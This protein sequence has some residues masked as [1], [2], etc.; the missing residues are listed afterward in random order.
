MSAGVS[1][2]RVKKSVIA[3]LIVRGRW[4]NYT[5]SRNSSNHRG[6]IPQTQ[7]WKDFLVF[8]CRTLGLEGSLPTAAAVPAPAPAQT[9]AAVA[10][11][12]PAVPS[13]SKRR[14]IEKRAAQ[15]DFATLFQ[16]TVS[17]VLLDVVYDA[18]IIKTVVAL[19]ARKYSLS[20]TV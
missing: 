10:A 9:V 13:A 14:R 5:T 19:Q 7:A 11:Q 18:R 16:F 6:A 20:L 2:E 17:S 3:W 15:A 1:D 4:L 8:V 12:P